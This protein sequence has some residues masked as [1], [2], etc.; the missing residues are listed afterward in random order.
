[1]TTVP[2]GWWL[3]AS[4]GVPVAR[5]DAMPA[6]LT[7][8]VVVAAAAALALRAARRRAHGEG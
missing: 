4:G 8:A 2:A 3:A 7:V 6:A 1:M 5:G